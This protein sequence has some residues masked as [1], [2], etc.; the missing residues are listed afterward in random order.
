MKESSEK[1]YWSGVPGDAEYKFEPRNKWLDAS[2]KIKKIVAKVGKELDYQ[3]VGLKKNIE[4]T[5]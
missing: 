4:E 5:V 2:I 3:L 1:I